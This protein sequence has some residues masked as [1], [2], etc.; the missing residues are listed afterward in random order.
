MNFHN[1]SVLVTGGASGIGKAI[2]QRFM[3]ED[4]QVTVFDLHKPD[5]D[6]VF[7]LKHGSS[8]CDC[9]FGMRKDTT[10]F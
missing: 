6:V 9:T 4:A 5:Y 8:E 10:I 3:K 2:A 1:K 7:H